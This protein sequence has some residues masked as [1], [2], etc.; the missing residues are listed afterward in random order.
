MKGWI[1]ATSLPEA[2]GRRNGDAVLNGIAYDKATDRLF[3]TGKNWPRL[4]EITLIPP[5]AAR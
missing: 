1:D 4:Y 2:R 5:R 3:I